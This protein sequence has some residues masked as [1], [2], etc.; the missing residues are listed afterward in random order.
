MTA[1]VS[2]ISPISGERQ[3]FSRNIP[4]ELALELNRLLTVDFSKPDTHEHKGNTYLEGRLLDILTAWS[5]CVDPYIA[6]FKFYFRVGRYVD[7]ERIVWQLMN[8]L[9][10]RNTF[11]KNYRKLKSCTVDWLEY[12]SDQRHFLFCLKALGVIRLRRGKIFLAKKVL[13]KLLEL[14]PNDEIGG[15]NFLEIAESF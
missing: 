15:G 2:K 10:N 3:Y 6:L 13:W 7:S 4:D 14:D 11:T 5:A 9:A 12:D 8:L 1:S